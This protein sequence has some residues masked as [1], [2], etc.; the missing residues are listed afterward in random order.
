[1]H[2]LQAAYHSCHAANDCLQVEGE[3][4]T[5]LKGTYFRNGPGLQVGGVAGGCSGLML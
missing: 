2:G 1:M 5:D 3:I 4:P